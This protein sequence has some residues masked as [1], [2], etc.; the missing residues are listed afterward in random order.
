MFTGSVV[1]IYNFG[2]KYQYFSNVQGVLEGELGK[3]YD[4]IIS[5]KRDIDDKTEIEVVVVERS[6]N[7]NL[8]D[9][10]ESVLVPGK[11][12][13]VKVIYKD[14]RKV[15]TTLTSFVPDPDFL[16]NIEN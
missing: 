2:E 13:E 9:F 6:F 4:H 12:I 8:P 3:N 15:L 10:E 5:D 14:N 7:I 1:N 16:Y 11:K